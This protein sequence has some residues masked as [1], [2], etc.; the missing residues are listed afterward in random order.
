MAQD[1]F[2]TEQFNKPS[3]TAQNRNWQSGFT[4][5]ELMVV[6]AIAGILSSI[7]VPAY[8]GLIERNRLKEVVEGFKSDLM[9]AK[10][11]AIKLSQNIVISRSS[12][13]T[14]AWCYGL[15]IDSSCDCNEDDTSDANFCN[16][17]RV[18]GNNLS[19]LVNMEAAAQNN[20]TFDFRRGTI[21]AYGVT[22][23]TNTYTARVVFSD[24]GRVRICTPSATTGL[25]GYP[26]C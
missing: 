10:T 7:A 11:E 6:I 17:K 13:N 25:S 16:I 18:L 8:Q 3:T 4:L 19:S 22:F 2:L 5:V 21:G 23:S 26:S 24:I 1:N 14:G 20:S 9:F 15:N 12:G